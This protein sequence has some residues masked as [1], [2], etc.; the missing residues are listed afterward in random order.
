MKEKGSRF[1]A[2]MRD[3]SPAFDPGA[4]VEFGSTSTSDHYCQYGYNNE[5]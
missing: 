1:A 5:I 4:G 2:A 3:A